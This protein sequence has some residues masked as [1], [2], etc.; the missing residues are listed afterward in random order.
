[1]ATIRQFTINYAGPGGATGVSV[2]HYNLLSSTNLIA[3][4]LGQ[5]YDAWAAVCSDVWTFA[6][7]TEVLEIEDTTG[8]ITAA[9]TVTNPWQHVGASAEE[10]V[11][12][13]TAMYVRRATGVYVAGRRL[14]GRTYLPGAAVSHLSMG[15]W[16]VTAL[17]AAAS[18]AAECSTSRV[19]WHRPKGGSG[20]LAVSGG[21]N[22]AWA[23]CSSQRGRR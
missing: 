12:T 6:I 19:I 10:P 21:T 14:A 9:A 16:S 3:A 5:A 7:D 23:E 11:P 1:M 17:Q 15:E 8:E 18:W 2:L 13:A 4:D 20:G 22:T